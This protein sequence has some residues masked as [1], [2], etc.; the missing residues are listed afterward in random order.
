MVIRFVGV[1]FFDLRFQIRLLFL[2][3]L[4]SFVSNSELAARLDLAPFRKNV[5]HSSTRP[6]CLGRFHFFVIMGSWQLAISISVRVARTFS[7]KGFFFHHHFLTGQYLEM[8]LWNYGAK[9]TKRESSRVDDLWF[10]WSFKLDIVKLNKG[11]TILLGPHMARAL[12]LCLKVLTFLA[13][14]NAV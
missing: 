2:T 3:R 7:L 14:Y 4:W 8:C 12:A 6:Q 10:I 9:Q 5:V 13:K 11:P 1:P